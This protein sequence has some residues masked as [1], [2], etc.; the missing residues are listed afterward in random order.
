MIMRVKDLK[1]LFAK[2]Q[3]EQ[4]VHILVRGCNN[5]TMF[6]EKVDIYRLSAYQLLFNVYV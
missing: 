4:I 5:D 6:G 2:Y 3:D 1:D